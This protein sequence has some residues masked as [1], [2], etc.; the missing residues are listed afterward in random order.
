VKSA[1]GSGFVFAVCGLWL[2]QQYSGSTK[3][4]IIFFEV[5]LVWFLLDLIAAFLKMSGHRSKFLNNQPQFLVVFQFIGMKEYP[6]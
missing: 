1:G 2:N 6:Y 3:C 5:F 4:S